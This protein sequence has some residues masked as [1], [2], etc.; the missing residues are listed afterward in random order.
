M[1]DHLVYDLFGQMTWQLSATSQPRFTG[2]G[3][4]NDPVSGMYYD[5]ARWYDPANGNWLSQDPL[6]FAA[7]QTNLSE[8]CGNSPTNATDPSGMA[9]IGSILRLARARIAIKC[10]T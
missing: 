6:S 7:G 9:E 5:M 1:S 2:D 4:R 8:Y 3:M 10:N